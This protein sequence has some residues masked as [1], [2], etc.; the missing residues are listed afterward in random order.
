MVIVIIMINVMNMIMVVLLEKQNGNQSES[1]MP[2]P[3]SS[4]SMGKDKSLNP[5]PQ[6]PGGYRTYTINIDRKTSEAL[7]PT[8][9]P[10]TLNP[11]TLKT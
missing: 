6:T 9:I 1:M 2:T 7:I 11:K 3:P 8:L 10:E 5:K 4:E